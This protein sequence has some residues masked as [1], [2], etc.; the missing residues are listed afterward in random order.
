M[1]VGF[2][3]KV[4]PNRDLYANMEFLCGAQLLF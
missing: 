3:L 4:T 1:S 2:Y